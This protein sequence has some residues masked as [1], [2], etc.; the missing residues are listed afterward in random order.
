M[1]TFVMGVVLSAGLALLAVRLY[2]R[3]R[4]AAIAIATPALVLLNPNLLYLAATPMTERGNSGFTRVEK[5][6]RPVES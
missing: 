1:R 3:T 5:L 6:C 4:S 2:M